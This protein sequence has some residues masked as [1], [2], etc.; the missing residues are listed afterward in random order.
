MNIRMISSVMLW[1]SALL[2]AVLIG[3]LT[4]T[5]LGL[6]FAGLMLAGGL[7]WLA[8]RHHHLTVGLFW[9]LYAMNST[10]FAGLI[11]PTGLFYPI[12]LLMLLNG[13]TWWTD[14]RRDLS[15]PLGQ[16]VLY[17]CFFFL[18]LLSLFWQPPGL[19]ADLRQRLF[20]YGFGMLVAVQLRTVEQLRSLRLFL[21]VT[22]LVAAAWVVI[23]GGLSGFAYR[24]G[25]AVN[26]NHVSTIIGLGLVALLG[27]IQEGKGSAPVRF[28]LWTLLGAGLYAN[29]LLA[30]RGITLAVIVALAAMLWTGR[31]REGGGRVLVL[32]PVAGLA[33]LLPG[34]DGL[35]DRLLSGDLLTLNDRLPI[36][37][38]GL[39]QFAGSGMGTLLFGQGMGAA[40]LLVRSV[41][42][43]LTSMHNGY[44][45]I[46]VEFGILGLG[47]FVALYAL[48]LRNAV[49]QEPV[50]GSGSLGMLIFLGVAL[51]S[52]SVQDGF[53]FWAAFGTSLYNWRPMGRWSA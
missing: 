32:L 21:L 8:L 22:G 5:P 28:L 39:E 26:P 40:E 42:P 53:L 31:R 3:I 43:L 25:V 44:I 30:S 41:N 36:W 49:Q 9:S 34:A 51:L 52:A 29:F 23:M 7:A 12:Y 11:N 45:Q 35:I 20:I 4:T 6:P 24:A 48:A 18:V 19:Q 14:R 2:L 10:V 47:V 1:L 15:I 37:R 46:L 38:Y 33:L 27:R 13:F 17:G 50:V 16:V